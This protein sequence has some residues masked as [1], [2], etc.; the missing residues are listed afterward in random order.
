MK[1]E[2]VCKHTENIHYYEA[3]TVYSENMRRGHSGV[4]YEAR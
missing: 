3:S 2:N 1:R 4:N